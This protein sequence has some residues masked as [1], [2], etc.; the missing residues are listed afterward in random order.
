M[1]VPWDD[2]R[3]TLH[4][5][6]AVD[7]VRQPGELFDVILVDGSDPVGPAEGLFTSA[8]YESCKSRLTGSGVLAL[9][10]EAPFLMREDFVRIV[11]TLR[12]TFTQVHPY[13]GPVPIYP[14]GSWSYTLASNA[15]DPKAPLPERLAQIEPVCRYYNRDIHAAAFA[16]PNDLRK[17]LG[18]FR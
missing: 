7:Y 8:F 9:Q 16:L 5:A 3:L 6:D 1:R 12:R 2:A 13:F 14:S 4:F 11:E 15:V 10:S 17:A 18:S